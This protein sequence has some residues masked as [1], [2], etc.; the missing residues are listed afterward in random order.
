MTR[1]LRLLALAALLL[2]A[3]SGLT[4]ASSS[5]YGP[6]LSTSAGQDTLRNIALWEDQRVTGDGKLLDYVSSGSPLTRRRAL[7]AVGRIQEPADAA[8]V[9]PALKDPNREVVREAIFALGQMDNP[10]AVPALLDARP[11][12][13][14]E[15][16]AMIAEALGKIGGNAVIEPLTDMVRDFNARVRAAAALAL[17]R[18]KDPTAAA[19]LM[20]SVHDPDPS[21][22]WRAIYAMEKQDAT[23]RACAT[24]EGFL[25]DEDAR[26]R[27][28]AARTLGKLSCQSATKGLI[29]RLRDDDIHV[30]IN[31]ERALGE[32]KARDAVR[33][34]GDLLMSHKSFHV[35][36]AAAEAIEKIGDKG[37]RDALMQG[38]LDPSVLVRTHSV[39]ALAV[40]LG[41]RSEMFVDEA[42]RDG[43]RLVRAEAIECYGRAGITNRTREL[44]EIANGDKDPMMRAAAVRALGQIKDSAIP[45]LLPSLLRDPDFT[46]VAA[47][48]DAIGEHEYRDA[49]PVLMETYDAHDERE[50]VDVQLEVVRVLGEMGAVEAE[51]LLVDAASNPDYRVRAAA[52]ESLT[53]LGAT[54]PTIVTDRQWR[55][56][57][58]DPSRRKQLAPPSGLHHAVIATGH[59]DIEVEL[60]G[61][62]AIQTVAMFIDLAKKH[63]YKG[64]TVHRVVPNF[65]IQGG[66]P[67]GDGN[68]DAGFT[69]PAEVSRHHFDEGYLGIADAGKDTGSC[70][71]FITLSPQPH[72]DGRYTIF[73]RVTRGMNVVWEMDRGDTF[74]VR[75]VD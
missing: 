56:E 73:G 2:P 35:R 11:G 16:V 71:W 29:H 67:R 12:A 32:L 52:V 15:D 46:V 4:R 74:D 61:D 42:R 40:C 34:L 39:R 7:E 28:A 63:F 27:A 49:I 54:P 23:P 36:A 10:D 55:E 66:D 44:A 13:P 14:A 58:F 3:T 75:I 17:A 68:G 64:L 19:T 51:S 70:Q 60:F 48:V 50:F 65:V 8:R 62:D 22:R 24:I 57:H 72:L 30:V 47:A 41:E 9:I 1:T 37:G 20:L 43:S 33:P 26:V 38:L 53:K 59:G 25:D 5:R 18:T 6:L 45:P 69:V 31:T 21:V